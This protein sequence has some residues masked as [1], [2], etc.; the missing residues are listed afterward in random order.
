M[1]F[2]DNVKISDLQICFVLFVSVSCVLYVVS[3]AAACCVTSVG[4][5]C[6]IDE[7]C[8]F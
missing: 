7:E 6:D 3:S 2:G 1:V 8:G 4:S 5:P